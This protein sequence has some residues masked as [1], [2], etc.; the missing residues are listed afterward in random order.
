MS[1]ESKYATREYLNSIRSHIDVN[2]QM[3]GSPL[4]DIPVR[5]IYNLTGE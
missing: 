4:T 1:E 5:V 2:N 3:M